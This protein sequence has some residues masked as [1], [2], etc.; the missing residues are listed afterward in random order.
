MKKIMVAIVAALT[1]TG[2]IVAYEA[3]PA[4]AATYMFTTYYWYPN[5]ARMFCNTV[6]VIKPGGRT[7]GSGYLSI[8]YPGSSSYCYRRNTSSIWQDND[9]ISTSWSW[10]SALYYVC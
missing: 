6:P 7:C 4:Q 2:G 8:K 10:T 5:D 1:L 3:Q 9:G